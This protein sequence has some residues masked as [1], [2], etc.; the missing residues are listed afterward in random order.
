MREIRCRNA[1]CRRSGVVSTRIDA[2]PGTSMK[3]EGRRRVSYG[4]V[5]WHTRQVQAM[6]GTPCDVPLPRNVT[7][8]GVRALKG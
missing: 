8:A 1:C 4:S 5:D 2:R 7:R 6:S 3:M